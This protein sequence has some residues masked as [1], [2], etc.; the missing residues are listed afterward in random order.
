MKYSLIKKGVFLNRPN[1]FIANVSIDGREET[2]HVKNTGRCKEILIHGTSVVLE[3]SQNKERKTRYSL[4]AAYKDNMLINIDSQVPNQVVFEAVKQGKIEELKNISHIR[5]ETKYKNSRFDLYYEKEGLKGFVEIK[6]VTLE[7]DGIAKFPD[8]PTQR[9]TKHIYEI[10]NSSENGYQSFIF[11][12]IQFRGVKYFTPNRI[13]DES[14]AYALKEAH[15]KGIAILV[16]DSIVTENGID[17]G[18][19]VELKI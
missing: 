10:I 17:L 6:G 2:V 11:F 1:R 13:M 7:K 3:E 14:F 5:K 15:N 16:Y 9:G 8:A 18:D 12:L 4:I 19:M